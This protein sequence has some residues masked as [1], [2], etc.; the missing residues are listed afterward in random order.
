MGADKLLK[1]FDV[2][3]EIIFEHRDVLAHTLYSF[4]YEFFRTWRDTAH[5]VLPIGIEEHRTMHDVAMR[6]VVKGIS[7][8]FLPINQNVV[9][10]RSVGF[11]SQFSEHID[12]HIDVV[13]EGKSDIFTMIDV[14]EHNV[15]HIGIYASAPAF[16]AIGLDAVLS[17]VVQIDFVFDEL[18]ASED[19]RRVHLPHEETLVQ[20]GVS[21]QKLFGSKVKREFS[22]V[23]KRVDD[24]V[25]SSAVFVLEYGCV[26]LGGE[27]GFQ[28]AKCFRNEQAKMRF[29]QV[30]VTKS[31]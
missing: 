26:R 17:T 10:S 1:G 9:P 24:V 12:H 8:H 3:G 11:H 30:K 19:D 28:N 29:F 21:C 18:V 14:A 31:L 2:D 22:D 6:N 20:I 27:C 25:H 15:V 5:H 13:V 7:A 16:A 4:R 23:V